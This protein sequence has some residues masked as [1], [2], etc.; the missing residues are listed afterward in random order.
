[1]YFFPRPS[2]YEALLNAAN[3]KVSISLITNGVHDELSVNNSTRIIYGHI[4]RLNYFPIMAGKRFRMWE[5]FDA[6]KTAQKNTFIFELDLQGI[7][8]H[9]KVMTVDHRYSLIGSYNLGMKS[10][11]AAYEVAAVIDSPGAAAQMEAV[12]NNDKK[13]SQE[14]TYLRAMGWYFNPY[15]NIAE[16]FE[17]KFFDGILLSTDY[18]EEENEAPFYPDEEDALQ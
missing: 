7:L 1:M 15:Y 9:K 6:K 12:L 5:L 8:Y 14:V 18:E 3:R 2:I 16:S 10:E 17:K 11:D 13:S 4:N